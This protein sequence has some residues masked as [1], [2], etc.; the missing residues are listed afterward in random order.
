MRTAKENV[1]SVWAASG[2]ETNSH[3]EQ[4][5]PVGTDSTVQ[6][7]LYTMEEICQWKDEGFQLLT[8]S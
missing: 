8:Q 3:Q 1:F 4:L 6:A 5:N 2:L 7:E